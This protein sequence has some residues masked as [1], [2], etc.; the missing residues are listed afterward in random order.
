MSQIITQQRQPKQ[1]NIFLSAKWEQLI[2]WILQGSSKLVEREN[3]LL[4]KQ[5][6]IKK[7]RAHRIKKFSLSVGSRVENWISIEGDVIFRVPWRI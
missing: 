3:R 2:K 1:K 4:R 6:T 7:Y 5:V